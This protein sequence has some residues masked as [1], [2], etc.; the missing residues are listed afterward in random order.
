MTFRVFSLLRRRPRLL[1]S[2]PFY[3]AQFAIPELLGSLINFTS[4]EKT[5]FFVF[6]RHYKGILLQWLIEWIIRFW[7]HGRTKQ[8]G[9]SIDRPTVKTCTLWFRYWFHLARVGALNCFSFEIWANHKTNIWQTIERWKTNLT[10]KLIYKH[11]G[12]GET[13]M[14]TQP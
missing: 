2:K 3:I 1:S 4:Q 13:T 11:P 14:V 5:R 8:A 10:Q 7:A 9:V 12:I 6:Q